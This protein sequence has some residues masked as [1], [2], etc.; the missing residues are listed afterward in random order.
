[1]CVL[2]EDVAGENQIQIN[3]MRNI[4]YFRTNDRELQLERV[5]ERE[6]EIMNVNS[7]KSDVRCIQKYANKIYS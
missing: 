2:S 1:M 4:I 6:R 7:N 5:K 3:K